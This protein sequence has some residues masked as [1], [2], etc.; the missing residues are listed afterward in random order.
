[1]DPIRQLLEETYFGNTLGQYLAFF[2]AVAGSLVIGRLVYY[3]F[4]HQLK[5]IAAKS[6]GQLDDDLLAAAEEPIALALVAGGLHFGKDFLTLTP[7]LEQ[8][9]SQGALVIVALAVTWFVLRLV[10]VGVKNYLQPLVQKTEGKLDDQVLPIIRKSAKTVIAIL[11]GIVVLSNLGYDILSVLAGLGIGGLALA[12]AAQ[13]ALKNIVG[14]VT[15]FWD[16]PFQV[17]DWVSVGSH[18]G[19]V[20]EIGLRSTRLRTTG[21]TTI[22]IPNSKIADSPIENYSS[23]VARRL[24]VTLGLT[25]GSSADDLQRAIDVVYDTIRDLDGTRSDDIL[26]RFV[27][28]GSYSLDLEIVYWITDMQN[29]RMVEHHANMALKRNLDAAG[30]EMAFPTETHHVISGNA[31]SP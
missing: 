17:K 20:A 25:Y 31:S 8:I 7:R 26:V 4:K 18:E 2:G 23:R 28:F 16:K 24:Q 3:L 10:D 1:M 9:L 14:G 19:E 6:E 5:R 27:H 21:G 13:D 11:A 12:L 30:V 22:V 29:W 15:I